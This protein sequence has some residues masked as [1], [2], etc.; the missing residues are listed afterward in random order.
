MFAFFCFLELGLSGVGDQRADDPTKSSKNN[1]SDELSTV[2]LFTKRL[3]LRKDQN[4]G[5][6]RGLNDKNQ[7]CEVLRS[8]SC[9]LSERPFW[10]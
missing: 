3:V 2:E 9:V 7:F 4:W 5:W 10:S 6:K 1:K 8:S